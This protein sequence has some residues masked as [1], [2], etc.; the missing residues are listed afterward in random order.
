MLPALELLKKRRL[1]A[2]LS[3]LFALFLLFYFA[4]LQGDVLAF[5]LWRRFGVAGV[6]PWLVALLLT[7]VLL[8]VHRLVRRLFYF[9]D[10]HYVF[11][12]LPSAVLAVLPT[13]FVPEPDVFGL[14]CCAIALTAFLAFHVADRRRRGRDAVRARFRLVPRTT[15]YLMWLSGLYL[16]V[17]VAGNGDVA[18]HAELRLARLLRAADYDAAARQPLTPPFTRQQLALRAYA[19]SHLP[20][21]LGEGLFAQPMPAASHESLFLI[22]ADARRSP[23]PARQLYAYL[24]V[25]PRSG[26]SD[27]AYQRRLLAYRPYAVMTPARD[28]ALCGLL[29]DQQLSTFREALLR[30]LPPGGRRHLPRAWR[31]ALALQARL[32]GQTPVLPPDASLEQNLSDFLAVRTSLPTPTQQ[33]NTLASLY[34]DTYWWYFFYAHLYTP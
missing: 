15:W 24:G 7:L 19:L 1:H 10:R 20:G 18:F 2:L 23:F 12:F 11:S 8:L 3:V 27:A 22:P 34:G 13:A 4:R 29:L 16:F 30:Y 6:S 5:V 31:E 9:R 33:A 14:V 26:E 32:S 28:Y 21:G 17:G 25:M